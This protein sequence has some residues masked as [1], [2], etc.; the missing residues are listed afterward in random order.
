VTITH[1]AL[2]PGA[3]SERHAHVRSEQ[4]WIV[5]SGEGVLLLGDG[6]AE[7]IRA[8][9]IVRTPAGDIHGVVNSGH[10][11]LAYLAITTPPQDFSA[12]YTAPPPAG[13]SKV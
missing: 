13:A 5:E 11:P 3:V 8:G 2:E 4:I 12:A 7:P 9:D 6:G 10:E 1:V